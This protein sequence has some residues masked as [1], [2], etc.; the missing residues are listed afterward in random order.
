MENN[1]WLAIILG[2]LASLSLNVGKGVQK[3]KVDV[4]KHK[5]KALQ[6]EHRKEFSIWLGG[7]LMTVFAGPFYSLAFK[8]SDQPSLVTSLGGVGLIGVLIFSKIV[9]K[10]HI[11]KLKVFGGVLII[12]G[13]VMVNYFVVKGNEPLS[14]EAGVF[15]PVGIGYLV[16][17]SLLAAISYMIKPMTGRAMAVAAGSCLGMSMILA[18]V[19]LVSAGGDLIGQ[20][21]TFYI[22]VALLCGNFA[23]I[24]TQLSLMR[25]DGSVVIPIIHSMVIIVSI[26]MEYVIYGSLLQ[27]IQMIGIA[28]IILGV[29]FLTSKSKQEHSIFENDE[30]QVYPQ[31]GL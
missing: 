11:T 29:F 21:K 15:L 19:A 5:L 31:S 26:I 24:I 28:V 17:F 14:F 12:I 30:A 6:P 22:Y 2:T 27:N 3:W 23:F 8:F 10:E 4:L 1:L 13:T 25:E 20:L 7:T 9:L 16:M 18:D